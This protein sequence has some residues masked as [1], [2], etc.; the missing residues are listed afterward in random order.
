MEIMNN[1]YDA[2]WQKNI[3]GGVLNKPPLWTSDNLFWH[4]NFFNKYIGENVLDVGC[5]DGTFLNFIVSKKDNIQLAIGSELSKEAIKIGKEKY[6]NV[7]FVEE[8]L[9]NLSFK[10]N[11][12]DTIFAIEVL[13]HILDIDKCLSEINRV[14]K[15]GGFFCVTTTDFNLLKKIVIATFFWDK[16]FYPNNPHIRFFTKK[17]LLSICRKYG[18]HLNDYK[19][20]KHYFGL[21]PKGQMAVFKKL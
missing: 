3:K 13:E 15:K 11:S 19:W 5:G 6:R 10:N 4:Y 18:L 17:T 1:Y 12:F 14:L 8:N 7:N 21:M 9:D 16:F 20:N 2:Y